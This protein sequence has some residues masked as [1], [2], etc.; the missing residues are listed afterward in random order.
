MKL[1]FFETNLFKK[2]DQMKKIIELIVV[3]SVSVMPMLKKEENNIV[4]VIGDDESHG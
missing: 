2:E 4:A 3:L 1:V